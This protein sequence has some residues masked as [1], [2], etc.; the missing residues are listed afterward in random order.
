[1]RGRGAQRHGGSLIAV[2]PL[3]AWGSSHPFRP[4]AAAFRFFPPERNHRNGGALSKTVPLRENSLS[5]AKKQV[6][7]TAMGF[8]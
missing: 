2:I 3:L 7:L 4:P 5:L 8:G 1:M 6:K